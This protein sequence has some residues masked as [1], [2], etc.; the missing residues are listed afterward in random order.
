[1][2]L[3]FDQNLSHRL[4]SLVSDL[5]PGSDHVRRLGMTRASDDVIWDYAK[6]DGFVLVTKDEDY[7][8]RSL[9]IG[10]PPKILWIRSGNCST[11]LVETL[12]R[13]NYV[14][15]E[16]FILQSDVGFLVLQ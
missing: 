7:H 3:L 2:K 4:V 6:G 8:V 12:L 9:L 16:Q 10:P 13:K 11:E 1:V 5:Y 15:I 14:E